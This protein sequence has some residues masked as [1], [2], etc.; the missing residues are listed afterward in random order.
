MTTVINN[1]GAFQYLAVSKKMVFICPI[2]P[3]MHMVV[4]DLGKSLGKTFSDE[5]KYAKYLYQL[6][7]TDPISLLCKIA[8]LPKPL[9]TEHDG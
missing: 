3:T 2:H 5:K 9:P 7:P 8:G 4:K 1:S 6:F